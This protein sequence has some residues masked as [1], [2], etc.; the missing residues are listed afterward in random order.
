MKTHQLYTHVSY[1]L[2]RSKLEKTTVANGGREFMAVQEAAIQFISI[3]AA[4]LR[5]KRVLKITFT[6]LIS[7]PMRCLFALFRNKIFVREM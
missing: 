5:A 4:N 3:N 1:A 2:L 7:P 6:L